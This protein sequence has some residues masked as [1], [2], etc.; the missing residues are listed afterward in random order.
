[1]HLPFRLKPALSTGKGLPIPPI[2]P[3]GICNSGWILAIKW[4]PGLLSLQPSSGTPFTHKHHNIRLLFLT[5]PGTSA[6]YILARQPYLTPNQNHVVNSWLQSMNAGNFN[7]Q[8]QPTVQQG[9]WPWTHLYAKVHFFCVC[10]CFIFFFERKLDLD[11]E[12]DERYVQEGS[13]Y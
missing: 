13:T 6:M 9:C 8:I 4:D 3:N 5:S 1:M 12:P 11:V 10:V 2:Q 7:L